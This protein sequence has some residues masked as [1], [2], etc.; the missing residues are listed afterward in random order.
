MIFIEKVQQFFEKY[1]K[2]LLVIIRQIFDI[3][4]NTAYM[5]LNTTLLSAEVY[6]NCYVLSGI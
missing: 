2:F 1:F 4:I 6:C 5:V 3:V